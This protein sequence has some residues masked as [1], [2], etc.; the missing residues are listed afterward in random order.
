[1]ERVPQAWAR[2]FVGDVIKPLHRL[3]GAYADA[4]AAL[5]ADAVT[6]RLAG[7]KA[8]QEALGHTTSETTERHYLTS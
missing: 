6:A 2:P 3:R 7:V 5:T 1:M 4:V 8:A